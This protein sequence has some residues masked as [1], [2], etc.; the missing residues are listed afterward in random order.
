MTTAHQNVEALATAAAG[1]DQEA[2]GRLLAEIRPDVLRLCARF[3]PC[4]ADAEDACQDSLLAV[5]RGISGFQG[6]S[7]FRTWLYRIAA[8]QAQ[9]NFRRRYARPTTTSDAALA[10]AADP[11]RTSMIAGT[12][13]DLHQGLAALRPEF[14]ESVVLRDVIGLSYQEIAA[15]LEVPLGTA[16]SWVHDGRRQ[17]RERVTVTG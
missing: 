6:R 8:N 15:A 2:L 5:A 11:R 13:I 12:Q 4:H 7:A 1:G 14:A 17:L 10:N 9:A 3:L 16:K